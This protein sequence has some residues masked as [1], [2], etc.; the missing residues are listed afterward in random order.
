MSP[1]TARV[2]RIETSVPSR[3]DELNATH[4]ALGRAISEQCVLVACC[5][6]Y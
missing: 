1:L 4:V 3:D 6:S 5:E 2:C